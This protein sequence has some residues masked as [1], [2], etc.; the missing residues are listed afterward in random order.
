M[1]PPP[2]QRNE[3]DAYISF[4]PS[5]SPLSLSLSLFPAAVCPL[6]LHMA[7]LHLALRP[8]LL[9]E[10]CR[11]PKATTPN[12]DNRRSSIPNPL[13]NT[14]RSKEVHLEK[15]I[16]P[17]NLFVHFIEETFRPITIRRNPPPSS[18][19]QLNSRPP[20]PPFPLPP[21]QS[22]LDPLLSFIR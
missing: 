19:L 6:T 22:P 14:L 15:T 11:I 20:P 1:T 3:M 2:V 10:V 13:P 9:L 17:K 4:S 12:R 16:H 7:H 8:V 5:S 21:L 18:F